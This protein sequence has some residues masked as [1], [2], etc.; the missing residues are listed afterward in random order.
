MLKRILFFVSL[1]FV[2]ICTSC[3]P[4]ADFG[5]PSS[6]KISSK[7]ETVDI[8]GNNDLPP[9]IIHIQV[10]DYDGNGNDSGLL[11]EDKDYIDT[12]TDWLT[13]KYIFAENK[14]VLN[15]APNETKKNRKLYLYLLDGRSRQEI[16]VTQSK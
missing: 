7:G 9:G 14:L 13:V 2:V 1:I 16:T 4:E 6:I 12:T 10:L 11:S 5:F 15:A 3:E 8:K